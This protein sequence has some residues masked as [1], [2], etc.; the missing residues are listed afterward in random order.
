MNGGNGN[1]V[2]GVHVDDSEEE[3]TV[4]LDDGFEIKGNNQVG[5]PEGSSQTHFLNFPKSNP[6]PRE[7]RIRRE[8]RRL[9]PQ[10]NEKEK[11][12]EAR[13]LKDVVSSHWR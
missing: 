3:R 11:E 6:Y 10:E 5:G 4:G 13:S 1:S 2:R 8:P 9:I 12:K 7:K